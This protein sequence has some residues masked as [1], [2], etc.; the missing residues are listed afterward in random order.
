MLLFRYEVCVDESLSTHQNLLEVH[1]IRK[2]PASFDQSFTKYARSM[3]W[4]L[5]RMQKL[6]ERLFPS[7][8]TFRQPYSCVCPL[9]AT[10]PSPCR[11]VRKPICGTASE[12]LYVVNYLTSF[13]LKVDILLFRRVVRISQLACHIDLVYMQ[14]P[15]FFRDFFSVSSSQSSI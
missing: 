7:L 6:R 10:S 8:N 1:E 11:P 12:V 4:E 14:G 3:C 5:E 15:A 9:T 2:I 13:Y